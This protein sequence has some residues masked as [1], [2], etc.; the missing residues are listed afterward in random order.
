[1][2]SLSL[3]AALR[4]QYSFYFFTALGSIYCY[5]YHLK[6]TWRILHLFRMSGTILMLSLILLLGTG[7]SYMLGVKYN[8]QDSDNLMEVIISCSASIITLIALF[9]YGVNIMTHDPDMK[10]YFRKQEQ[11]SQLRV[12]ANQIEKDGRN[13]RINEIMNEL[14]EKDI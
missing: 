2:A 11:Y 12:K 13:E 1:M 6:D 4:I 14:K 5:T 9:V 8:H 7:G 10:E 3:L